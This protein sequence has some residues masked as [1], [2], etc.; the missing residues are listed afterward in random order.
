MTLVLIAAAVWGDKMKLNFNTDYGA[1]SPYSIMIVLAFIVGLYVQ[2]RFNLNRGISRKTLFKLIMISPAASIICALLLTYYSSGGQYIGLSSMG[3]LVGMYIGVLLSSVTNR[4]Y[5]E[6]R[7]M[8]ENCTFALPLMYSISK[9]GCLFAGCCHGKDYNGFLSLYYVTVT[10][11][12]ITVFPVQ[13]LETIIFF[14]IFI[15]GIF[16][17]KMHSRKSLY[18]TFGLSLSAKFILDY[19]RESHNGQIISFNQILCVV[20]FIIVIGIN[21]LHKKLN[22]KAIFHSKRKIFCL[23][24]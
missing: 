10:G 15:V 21:Q 17:Y 14:I 12:E 7:V 24:R 18:V 9:I 1:I 16:L 22:A 5:G 23:K 4:N 2:C 13:L 20:L 3:G 11:T 6:T 19:F 8:V